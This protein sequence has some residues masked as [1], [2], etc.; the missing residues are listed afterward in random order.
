MPVNLSPPGNYNTVIASQTDQILSS[1]SGGTTGSRGDY[2]ES[3]TI[4][5]GSATP[6]VVTLKD[7]TTAI[8]TTTIGTATVMPYVNTLPI[9]AYSKTGAW[10]VSTGAAVSVVAVG[11]FT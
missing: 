9:R 11:Q 7:G 5:A 1:V 6:G 10:K 8:L 4:N 3:I 2:L